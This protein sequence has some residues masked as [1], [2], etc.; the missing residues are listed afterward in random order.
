MD[1]ER[2]LVSLEARISDF[3]KKMKRAEKTGTRTFT[4]MQRGSA[5]ATRQFERD[6]RRQSR[7]VDQATAKASGRIGAISKAAVGGLVGAVA[8][9]G[10]TQLATETARV[11]EGIAAIGDEAAR[12][13]LSL[14]EFQEWKFVAEQNRI[15]I[16]AMTDGFK[17]LSLRADEFVVTGKGPAAEAFTRLGFTADQLKNK[18][19]DPSDLML[20]IIDRLEG[21][22]RAAQ[23]RVADEIFGGTGGEQ[24]VQLLAQGRMEVQRTIDEAGRLGV[25]MDAETIAKAEELDRKFNQIKASVS[26]LA[27]TAIV[28]FT[29]ALTDFSQG[30][31]EIFRD[32][33]G[34]RGIL[35]DKTVDELEKSEELLRANQDTLKELADLYRGM[36]LDIGKAGGA[37]ANE[38][39]SLLDMD[40]H[41]AAIQLDGVVTRMQELSMDLRAGQIGADEFGTEMEATL[42]TA[43]S[44][45]AEVNAIDGLDL[46]FAISQVAALTGQLAGAFE[47]AIQLRSALPGATPRGGRGDGGAEVQARRERAAQQQANDS[48]IAGEKEK[49]ALSREQL[50]LQRETA[51]VVDRAAQS[52]AKLTQPQAERLA[53]ASLE[54][55]QRRREAGRPAAAPTGSGGGGGRAAGV[56]DYQRAVEGMRD[57]AAALEIETAQYLEAAASAGQYEYALAKAEAKAKLM[58]AAQRDGLR[59]TP[60]LA[61][62]MDQLAAG[63]AAAA[64]QADVARDQIESVAAAQQEFRDTAKDSFVGLVSGATSFRDALSQIGLKLAELSASK[65][66]DMTFPTSG[67]TSGGGLFGS[68]FAGFFDSGG[69]IPG[70]QFGIVGE[71]GPEIVTG[72]AHVTSRADTAK[73]MQGGGRHEVVVAL[74]VPEG[75]TVEETRQI[76][77]DIAMSVVQANNQQISKQNDPARRY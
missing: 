19:K 23:I 36:L 72:P 65:L 55:D 53:L 43:S 16:D 8:I 35:G 18:L 33:S 24:F 4:R 1:Q 21:M 9:S 41:D 67:G 32:R 60:E 26:T 69:H 38:I 12:S 5:S 39:P 48:F 58:T 27:K 70:G 22:D 13:N 76:A 54:A 15:G 47:R 30:L 75:V 50:A 42:S 3:E 31:D 52:G 2:L 14:Y 73:M 37:I 11:V 57:R 28:E 46:S 63:Y 10:L 71:R 20:D 51:A 17:E 6:M 7:A 56:S 59:V 40:A 44:L 45:L 62:G 61:A 49:N 25:V 64:Q 29:F 74:A 77:G 68:L 66:F 34:G